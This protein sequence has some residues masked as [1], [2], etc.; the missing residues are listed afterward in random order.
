VKSRDRVALVIQRP[1]VDER[2]GV[3][4]EGW[5]S[6]RSY[7]LDK[8]LVWFVGLCGREQSSLVEALLAVTNSVR[9]KVAGI[10]VASGER[11]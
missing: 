1:D 2:R 7:L 6:K 8:G 5:R 10:F 4:E 9:W 11:E 3:M